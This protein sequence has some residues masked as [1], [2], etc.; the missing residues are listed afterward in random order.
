MS[1]LTDRI[2]NTPLVRLDSVLRAGTSPRV[3][4][5]AKLE[6]LNPGG[7]V[8]DRAAWGII[9]A[10]EASGR[11]VPGVHL[12]D[13]SSGNT[14][15]AYGMIAATRGHRLTLC[16]PANA[17]VERKKILRAFGVDIVETD[18][19]EGSD[20]A[21][22]RARTLAE[23]QPHHYLYLDQYSNPEN[24]RAH[25]HG[26][27][28]EIWR[29]TGGR[30]THWVAGLGTTG[31][32]VGTTRGLRA[33][34]PAIQTIAVQPDAPFH[35]LEGL[36]FLDA[37]IIPRIYDATLVDRHIGAPT[38]ASIEMMRRLAREEGLLV[39]V[40]SGAAA[41]A[42]IEVAAGLEEGVVV[43]LF[44]D[45]GERYLSEAHLWP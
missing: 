18:P 14:G 13:S 7:S 45:S 23:E 27:A 12:L 31:T 29:D 24:P 2:G 39:G 43:T 11:L 30:V 5:W 28:Q 32:F 16:L 4:V 35:G 25:E 19:L 34:N 8:K 44:P 42:A 36:K 21:I 3:E 15:I 37:S 20:G 10:A 40:S 17:N 38:E 6:G 22:R 1:L 41:W 26:T 33:H 9:Q